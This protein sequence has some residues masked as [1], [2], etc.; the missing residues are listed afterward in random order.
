ML[1]DNRAPWT[2]LTNHP[3]DFEHLTSCFYGALG[4]VPRVGDKTLLATKNELCVA[5]TPIFDGTK[6]HLVI[7]EGHHNTSVRGG[8]QLIQ[9]SA[10][11]LTINEL[12]ALEPEF[13]ENGCII[14]FKSPVSADFTLQEKVNS[15]NFDENS[16]KDVIIASSSEPSSIDNAPHSK[17]I[18]NRVNVNSNPAVFDQSS[19][20]SNSHSDNIFRRITRSN[21]SNI[22]RSANT[23]SPSSDIPLSVCINF[24]EL[25]SD[26][27][28]RRIIVHLLDKFGRLPSQKQINHFL[29]LYAQFGNSVFNKNFDADE[30]LMLLTTS[31]QVEKEPKWPRAFYDVEFRRRWEPPVR[32]EVD[33]LVNAEA[34]ERTTL[35]Y[36]IDNKFTILDHCFP[37]RAKPNGTDKARLAICG[38]EE[39]IEM[40]ELGSLFAPSLSDHAFKILVATAAYYNL[41]LDQF[42]V[43]QCFRENKW[44]ETKN[45]R[46]IAIKLDSIASGTGREEYYI[47]WV[48][49]YGF[50]DAS[51][52][53]SDKI[54]ETLSVG[55]QYKQSETIP[56]LFIKRLGSYGLCLIGVQTDDGLIASSKNKEGLFLHDELIKH[57][58]KLYTITTSDP[59]NLPLTSLTFGGVLISIDS[60]SITLTQP[61]QVNKVRLHF[62]GT[63]VVPETFLPLPTDWSVQTSDSAP[64]GN[65][66]SFMSGL[67]IVAFCRLT[68]CESNTFSLLSSRM[69]NPS[70]LDCDALIHF[71]AFICTRVDVGITYYQSL[72]PID[73]KK[74][75]EFHMFS[76][77]SPNLNDAS[78]LAH[79][80]KIGKL[81]H[82]GGSIVAKSRK[83][84]GLLA[85]SVPAIEL[86]AC[87]D[88][89][90]SDLIPTRHVFEEIAGLVPTGCSNFLVEGSAPPTTCALDSQSIHNLLTGINGKGGK[91]LRL[92]NRLISFLR[93]AKHE[94][95]IDPIAVPTE[96]MHANLLTKQMKSATQY[97]REAVGPL[98]EHP[99]LTAML[100]RVIS[101]HGRS[102]KRSRLVSK[103]ENVNSD[104]AGDS[105]SVSSEPIEEVLLVSHHDEAKISFVE[106]NS[107]FQK[108][109]NENFDDEEDFKLDRLGILTVCNTISNKWL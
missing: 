104:S 26:H 12:K 67:G 100:N 75:I 29:L 7:L 41:D 52:T 107:A 90:K 81:G 21:S 28:M 38:N 93:S 25:Q 62:F 48:N 42:D 24:T 108:L 36:L 91:Q 82:P 16:S 1:I 85:T 66:K 79:I 17:Q 102:D 103:T 98:G 11:R 31:L 46:K 65:R 47:V 10:Q 83:Q 57:L 49:L 97:W 5:V 106:A 13:D 94:G 95:L 71:A 64:A 50:R 58:R 87:H 8:F 19:A 89:T 72:D 63:A 30:D 69:Q 14:E 105:N 80:L 55:L 78:Q 22:K 99:A 53:W 4:L 59:S 84:I 43:T 70:T 6:S 109:L 86:S 54:N 9:D 37:L 61:Q 68:M 3:I 27:E 35:Q 33:G 88:G 56:K 101:K 32:K 73:N 92:Y 39:P 20:A 18:F 60:N 15:F 77:A 23:V 2:Q 96:D 44:S 74:C 40:F 51:R 45:P 34:L 76:D